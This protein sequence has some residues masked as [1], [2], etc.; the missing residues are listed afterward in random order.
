LRERLREDVALP[1]IPEGDEWRPSDYFG[2]VE[3]AI[4]RYRR[5][6]VDRS[7]AGL[8]FFTFSKFMMWRDLDSSVWPNEGLV[9][10]DLLA[11]LLGESGE[12]AN[13]PPIALDDEPIDHKIDLS[14]A[15]HV[16]DADSSQAVV[17]EEARHGRNL[18]VQGPPGTGK[19]QTITNIIAAAVHAG[20][21][22][23]FVA[24]KTA[25]LEVVHSRL[26]RAGLSP[27]CLEMH[28]RK[29]NK[30]EVLKSLEEA[31]RFSGSPRFDTAIANQVASCRD[32]LNGWSKVVHTP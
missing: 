1:E 22:I 16:V 28:S 26:K 32:K 9:K 23:L 27:L 21:S 8:G 10:H 18:V 3:D 11:V 7:A 5:F 19:S 30:R 24:E 4:A 12:F 29:A 13:E 14:T 31:L 25:A 2:A 20:R 6:T 17:V 15:I